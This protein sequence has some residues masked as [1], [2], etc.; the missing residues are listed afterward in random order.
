MTSPQIHGRFRSFSVSKAVEAIG[1]ALRRIREDDGLSWKEAGRIL[2][3]SDDRAS[4]YAN[5][6]SEMPVGTFLLGCREWNGRFADD[7]LAMIGM[8]L[9][10]VA[11]G[12]ISDQSLQSR[13]AKLMYEVSIALEDGKIDDLELQRMKRTLIEAGEAV[14]AYRGKAA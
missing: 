11:G 4:D 3:K 9:V 10:P 13:L 7:A 12:D 2:G 8:K 5:A 14:D 6:L 1:S